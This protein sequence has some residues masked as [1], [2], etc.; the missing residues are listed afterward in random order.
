MWEQGRAESWLVNSAT[1]PESHPCLNTEEVEPAITW[2]LLLAADAVISYFTQQLL[3]E[4][5][6]SGVNIDECSD[7]FEVLAS[8]FKHRR[9]G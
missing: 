9:G 4:E 5:P 7:D 2:Q 1:E 8:Q 6:G 3:G